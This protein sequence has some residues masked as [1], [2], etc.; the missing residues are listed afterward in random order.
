MPTGVALQYFM[1]PNVAPAVLADRTR[2]LQIVT[3]AVS[4][5]GR[6]TPYCSTSRRGPPA[7]ADAHARAAAKWSACTSVGAGT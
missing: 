4:N 1:F 6:F 5:A 7:N 3:N 2:V